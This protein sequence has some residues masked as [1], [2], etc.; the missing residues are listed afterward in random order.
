MTGTIRCGSDSG[1][2]SN[3][4]FTA[5]ASARAPVP[6]AAELPSRGSSPPERSSSSR[7]RR[8]P[9]RLSDSE[10]TVG[11]VFSRS[12]Q[13]SLQVQASGCA[14]GGTAV[15]RRR[16]AA[17]PRARRLDGCGRCFTSV[18]VTTPGA[19]RKAWN[20]RRPTAVPWPKPRLRVRRA[21]DAATASGGA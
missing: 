18:S 20:G 7:G 4:A 2:H 14:H 11:A 13:F 3:P 17:S 6:Q 1:V 19:W 15:D 12:V 16:A 10:E 9:G 8:R 5:A 21:R